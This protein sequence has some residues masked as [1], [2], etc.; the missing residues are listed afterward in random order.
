[1]HVEFKIQSFG[2]EICDDCKKRIS[3]GDS[4]NFV[5]YENGKSYGRID[6]KCLKLLKKKCI[7]QKQL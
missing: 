3:R 7:R 4:I 6:D 2:V 1:M 5:V